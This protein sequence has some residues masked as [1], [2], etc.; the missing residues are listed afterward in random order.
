MRLK[1]Y[2]HPKRRA[3]AEKP[4]EPIDPYEDQRAVTIEAPIGLL[5]EVLAAAEYF[6]DEFDDRDLLARLA[7]LRAQ[8][9]EKSS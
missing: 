1:V 5:H 8:L 4:P 3:Q 6:A 9:D 2:Y 7:P